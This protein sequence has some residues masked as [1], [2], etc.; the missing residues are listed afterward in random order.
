MQ[1]DCLHWINTFSR[2]RTI[3][4]SQRGFALITALLLAMMYFALME[5]ILIDSSRAQA[6]AQRFRARVIASTMAESGAELAALRITDNPGFFPP[7]MTLPEGDVKKA[8][9]KPTASGF[10]LHGEG[11]AAGLIPQESDVTLFGAVVPSL[12]GPPSI[13]IDYA[14]HSQ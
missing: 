8:T 7:S 11:K 1:R 4:R 6:E 10:E 3:D 12:S 13:R 2:A 9:Y 5:L 14:V